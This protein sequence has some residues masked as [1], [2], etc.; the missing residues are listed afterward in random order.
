MLAYFL[1]L[2]SISILLTVSTLDRK[3]KKVYWYLVV[4]SLI[5]FSGFRYGVGVDYWSY[6]N[7]FGLIASGRDTYME[8]GFEWLIRAIDY[9][10]GQSQLMFLVTSMMVS[11]FFVEGIIK[12]SQKPELSI[13]LF[14]IIPIFY[15]ASFNGVRQFIAIAIFLWSIQFIIGRNIVKYALAIGFGAMFHV[16]ILLM[17]PLYF[18]LHRKF[19]IKHYLI[20]SV[21]Y[22]LL[23]QILDVILSLI[24][25]SSVVY[26][27]SEK[28]SSVGGM[29][30]VFVLIAAV[31][32][33]YR[34]RL[35]KRDARQTVFVNM[36]FLG[37]LV[38]VTPLFSDI[39]ADFVLR[40][41]SYF[42]IA[43]LFVLPVMLSL[44]QPVGA[45]VAS[46]A[47]V[48]CLGLVYFSYTIVVKGVGYKLVPYAMDASFFG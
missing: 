22:A 9:I 2:I 29:V 17:S 4:F 27:L 11:Y 48:V 5:I 44:V 16:S 37:A 24:G 46:Y 30:F 25:I 3:F 40:M 34:N 1:F 28:Q 26:L 8:F 7:H 38:G 35:E 13:L 42:T 6:V 41:T 14:S 39:P 36:L 20:I 19:T 31:A 10:G 15:F 23:F 45:R 33:F 43:L 21:A 47:S 32:L 12:N 18:V